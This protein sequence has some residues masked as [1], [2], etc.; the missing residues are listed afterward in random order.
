[1][2]ALS[3]VGRAPPLQGGCREFEPLSAHHSLA[4]DAFEGAAAPY[5]TR[6]LIFKTL[7]NVYFTLVAIPIFTRQP[8]HQR[9]R[10]RRSF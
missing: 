9:S 4:R 8:P 7:R 3:S 10:N 5:A 2:W 1:M 6:D